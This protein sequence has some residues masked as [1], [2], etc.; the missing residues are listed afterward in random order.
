MFW[1][2]RKETE[3]DISLKP[4]ITYIKYPG[5]PGSLDIEMI[6]VSPVFRDPTGS[7]TS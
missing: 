6:V 3:K 4:I 1:I 2:G 5:D 7:T